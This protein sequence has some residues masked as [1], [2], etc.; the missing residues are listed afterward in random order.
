MAGPKK[1]TKADDKKK[2]AG[3]AKPPRVR[4]PKLEEK[5]IGTRVI[6]SHDIFRNME[7]KIP[8]ALVGLSGDSLAKRVIDHLDPVGVF[9][10]AVSSQI[11]LLLNELNEKR[12]LDCISNVEF[13]VEYQA[14]RDGDTL[15]LHMRAMVDPKGKPDLPY[16]TGKM[17]KQILE[18]AF[19]RFDIRIDLSSGEPSYQQ[20]TTFFYEAPGGNTVGMPAVLPYSDVRELYV[21][22]VHQLYMQMLEGNVMEFFTNHDVHVTPE[23]LKMMATEIG[24][25]HHVEI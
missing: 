7:F 11:S 13:E 18:T 5:H 25:E 15:E 24:K 6:S 10:D 9:A 17:A 19:D 12:T 16:L 1:K 3:K 20:Q 8:V 22:V 2:V 23:A 21:A 14:D 4:K